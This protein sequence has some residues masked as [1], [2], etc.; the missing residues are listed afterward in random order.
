MQSKS[1]TIDKLVIELCSEDSEEVVTMVTAQQ[2]Q[3]LNWLTHRP[4]RQG[5][6]PLKTSSIKHRMLKYHTPLTAMA[7]PTVDEVRSALTALDP[8]ITTKVVDWFLVYLAD[9]SPSAKKQRMA[10]D[11]EDSS[12]GVSC[13]PG[14]LLW[15]SL[16]YDLIG[17]SNTQ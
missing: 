4:S 1:A 14:M 6:T 7:V 12:S 17:F 5:R 16:E 3:V 13:P 11:T 8:N 10:E 9:E 2:A 15:V